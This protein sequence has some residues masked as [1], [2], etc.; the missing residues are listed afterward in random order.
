MATW[1]PLASARAI[2]AFVRG[3]MGTPSPMRVPSRSS[4]T[5]RM[6][7]RGSALDTDNARQTGEITLDRHRPGRK[8]VGDASG[9]PVALVRP[10]LEQRRPAVGERLRQAPEKTGDHLESVAAA[11]ER[12]SRL[13]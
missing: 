6:G 5:R 2:A 8:D 13:E 10:D 11:V 12:D 3:P 1:M 9:N 4:T 7:R